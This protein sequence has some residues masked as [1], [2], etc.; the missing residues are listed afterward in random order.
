[1]TESMIESAVEALFRDIQFTK[2]PG[3]LYDALRYMIQIGGKRLRPRLCLTVYSLFKDSFDEGILG[4]TAGIEVFHSFTLIHDDIMDKSALRRGMPTV[5]TKWNDDTAILSGD[6]MCI[7]S[8]RRICQAPKECLGDVLELFNRTAAQVCEGQQYDMDFE[9]LSQVPMEDYMKMIGLKT[10]VLI[11]C[12]AAM[13]AIIGGAT[14]RECEELY[15]YGYDLGLAFQVADDYLDAYGDEKQFGKPIGGDIINGKKSWLTTKALEVAQMISDNAESSKDHPLADVKAQL[16]SALALPGGTPEEKAHKISTVKSI[17]EA[18]GI[19][20]KAKAQIL[21][22]HSSAL[23]HAASVLD[24]DR[25]KPLQTFADH[26]I[27]RTK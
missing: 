10:G 5:W 12:A 27:G 23:A 24:P 14:E 9:S 20:E 26:L 4:P 3:G 2:E 15:R 1:M 17:Y 19:P 22:L 16:L 8:Y 25:L 21:A 13:G 11:A 7:D 18:L 6:V